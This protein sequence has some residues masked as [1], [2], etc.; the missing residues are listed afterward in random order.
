MFARFILGFIGIKLRHIVCGHL[1]AG[2]GKGDSI[3]IGKDSGLGWAYLVAMTSIQIGRGVFV[4]PQVL[5]LTG[6][7]AYD[8][9]ELRLIDQ[10]K[11]SAPI[12]IGAITT[13][14]FPNNTLCVGVSFWI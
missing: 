11:V 9:P 6:G 1:F 3:S 2:I 12:W 10:E 14:G 8:N 4:A 5:S 13:K 7:H